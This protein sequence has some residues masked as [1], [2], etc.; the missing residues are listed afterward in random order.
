MPPLLSRRS[1]LI[2]ASL[3]PLASRPLV[4]AEGG[5]EA[6]LREIEMGVGGRL[7]IAALDMQSDRRVD[8]RSSHLFPMCSTFK[9]LLAGA[10]LSKIDHGTETLDREIPLTQA[11]ILDYAPVTKPL[12]AKG[13]ITVAQACA[14]AVVD[15][16]NSAANLLLSS[17]GG[18]GALTL[19]ARTLGDKTTHLD[20]IEPFLN[21]A[22]PGDARDTTSPAA[23]L[24]DLGVLVLQD[25]L[26]T[27]SREM[28]TYWLVKSSTGL[29][30]LRAGMPAGWKVG[31]KTGMGE[32]GST[33]DVAIAW[34]PG[35]KPLLIAA[36]LTE[37]NATLAERN[38]AL[39]DVARL[40]VG[41]LVSGS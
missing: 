41:E 30:K 34:P 35:R 12:L 39:A 27:A 18:P 23:M 31:D 17:I 13:K 26:S 7:G 4:A 9:L 5:L 32:R 16:D 33:C 20:R 38:K 1:L 22:M 10:V 15:S 36:Y 25:A 19:F 14:A 21:E 2:G 6:R 28:L 40:V 3:A 29:A 11:D 24:N 37:S 8:Y